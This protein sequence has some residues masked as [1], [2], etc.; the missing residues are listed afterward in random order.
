[1]PPTFT[2]LLVKPV[3]AMGHNL[4]R[5]DNVVDNRAVADALAVLVLQRGG[6]RGSSVCSQKDVQPVHG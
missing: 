3:H 4:R 2:Y 5:A 1:M 6:E